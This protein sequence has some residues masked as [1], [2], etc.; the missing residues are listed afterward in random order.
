MR[1]ASRRNC[2]RPQGEITAE[3]ATLTELPK[4][5][6]ETPFTDMFLHFPFCNAALEPK[7]RDGGMTRAVQGEEVICF[8]PALIE[9]AIKAPKLVMARKLR[10][11]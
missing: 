9:A 1:C 3:Q 5:V 10:P 2:T 6:A 4:V 8:V 7:L 11:V